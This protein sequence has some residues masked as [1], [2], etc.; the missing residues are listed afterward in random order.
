MNRLTNKETIND[1]RINELKDENNS[2]NKQMNE[3]IN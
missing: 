1:E 3:L 2:T